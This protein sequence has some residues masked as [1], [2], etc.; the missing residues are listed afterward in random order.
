MCS[1][2]KSING[3][4]ILEGKS[5]YSHFFGGKAFKT[6]LCPNCK[7]PMQLIMRFDTSDPALQSVHSILSSLPLVSCLNCSG[8]WETQFF[9]MEQEQVHLLSQNEEECWIA[10]EEDQLPSPLPEVPLQLVPLLEEEIMKD[11]LSDEEIDF[12]FDQFGTNYIG[13][14]FGGLMESEEDTREYECCYC[15]NPMMHLASITED[16][17]ENSDLI[18]AI[19]FQFG[20]IILSFFL[21]TECNVMRTE[22]LNS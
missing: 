14:L 12:I 9:K 16:M 7:K 4:K 22:N 5:E 8:C 15:G 13:R 1:S 18:N 2:Q 11:D 10:D 3:Y 21:C 6:P 20:E 17:S 19:S